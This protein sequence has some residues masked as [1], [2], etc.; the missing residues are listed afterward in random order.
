MPARRGAPEDKK[1]SDVETRRRPSGTLSAAT[2]G[3]AGIRHITDLTAKEVE[4]AT[5]VQPVEGGWVVDV[6]VLED[7]RI[8]SSGDILA[9]YEAELD[10]EGNLTSYQRKRRYRRGRSDNA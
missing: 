2:A 9:L 8:P 6:E 3:A 7:R 5:R 1:Q 4:G 10:M